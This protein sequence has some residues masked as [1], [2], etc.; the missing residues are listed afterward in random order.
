[1]NATPSPQPLS[2][3]QLHKT[4]GEHIA[5]HQLNLDVEPGQVLALLGPS[6]C[7][8]TTLLRAIAGLLTADS[9]SIAIRG[10]TVA[11]DNINLPPEQRG[12]GMVFQDYALWPH[13]TVRENLAFPLQMQKLPRSEQHERI[14]WALELVGLAHLAERS[15]GTLSGGQQQRIALARAIVAQP[16]LLLMDEPLSNLD[17]NL[18]AQLA[19]E[20][21]TLIDSLGLAA[22]F[23]THD[24]HEAFALAD[25]V[26]VMHQGRIA[27]LAAP[28]ELFHRPATPA[29]AEFL[30]A[31][32]LV[33]AQLT[34]AGLQLGNQLFSLAAPV[35]T[36][37]QLQLLLPHNAF[38]LHIN[39]EHSEGLLRGTV[40]SRLYQGD[41]YLADIQ[42]DWDDNT[43]ITL[44][45]QHCPAVN[46]PV[47]L[48]FANH[49]VHGWDSA[50]QPIELVLTEIAVKEKMLFEEVLI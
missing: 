34:A 32:S 29:I 18:R 47:R 8:K 5:L 14:L 21:R 35:T 43:V 22:V 12:L 3:R 6:G 19:L 50:G 42:L 48:A 38:T 44:H 17:K 27:Q 33:P 16:A 10:H 11:S 26:A 45:L 28:E 15:P 46:T 9:G 49:C 2:I 39:S 13:M 41:Y 7:G 31:G 37:G 36:Q 23:V 25:K 30:D 20:I 40:R 24:Q 4:F 1:M